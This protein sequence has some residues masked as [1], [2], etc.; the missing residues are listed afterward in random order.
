MPDKRNAGVT[1]YFV[2]YATRV[3]EN[4]WPIVLLKPNDKMPAKYAWGTTTFTTSQIKK[5]VAAGK[6][7]GI[8]I[9]CGNIIGL[10]DDYEE[11]GAV[12]KEF[13]AAVADLKAHFFPAVLQRRGRG[14]RAP[15]QVFRLEGDETFRSMDLDKFQIIASGRQFVAYNIHPETGEPYHWMKTGIGSPL[16]VKYEDIPTYTKKELMDF[17]KAVQLLEDT[18]GI[19][20]DKAA[21]VMERIKG[22]DFKAGELKGDKDTVTAACEYLQNPEEW[23]WE[24]WNGSLMM[25]L[26]AASGG[27]EWGREL[28]HKISEKNSQYDAVI[29]NKRWDDLAKSPPTR[30]GA[31]T[32]Y[33]QARQNGMPFLGP[34][35]WDHYK[36]FMD[37]DQ[38]YNVKTGGW[39]PK[40]VFNDYFSKQRE[41]GFT[42]LQT[43]MASRPEQCFDT[44]VWDPEK[45]GGEV[46]DG[47]KRLWN[48]CQMPT[49]WGAEGDVG[50]WLELMENVYEKHMHTII[51]R[52]A[53]DIQYPSAKP[54]WHELVIGKHGLG[55]NLTKTPLRNHFGEMASTINATALE[56]S[57]Q[58]FMVRKKHLEIV[59]LDAVGSRV[60]NKHK[61]LLATSDPWYEVNEKFL[62]PYRIKNV[63]STWLSSNEVDPLSLSPTER[64]IFVVH[65]RSKMLPKKTLL[66]TFQWMKENWK[67]VVW[68]LKHSV[69]VEPGFGDS[70]PYHTSEFRELVQT[71]GRAHDKLREQV[72]HVTRGSHVFGLNEL[73]QHFIEAGV[74]EKPGFLVHIETIRK[75]IISEGAVRCKGGAPIRLNGDEQKRLWSFDPD[76]ATASQEEIRVYWMT[77]DPFK[78]IVTD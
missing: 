57:F 66:D 13:L 9:R 60:F 36:I 30:I 3:S 31:G 71:A 12:T 32:L 54:Q 6:H 19:A 75:T 62:R 40:P 74:C 46:M 70:L 48:T 56:G 35:D 22:G 61:D 69:E 64:R 14:T 52:M 33:W 55:K 24:K 45:P 63:V 59:E 16:S 77:A 41:K 8:G 18:W 68:Y 17:L 42:P 10:D 11:G 44:V 58:S 15:L 51:K 1:N 76:M 73:H 43:F 53:F 2:K 21:D 25:P 78:A 5:M 37:R 47:S 28:A 67:N 29:T 7:Y 20:P 38:T 72:R 50:P 26:W 27:E 4:G 23:G 34:R 39:T 65:K 49:E